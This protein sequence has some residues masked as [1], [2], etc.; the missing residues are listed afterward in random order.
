MLCEAYTFVP[1]VGGMI[2]I[3]VKDGKRR[4]VVFGTGMELIA[5]NGRQ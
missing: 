5:L 4:F 3:G 1:D 2:E